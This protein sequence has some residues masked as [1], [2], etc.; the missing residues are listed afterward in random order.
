M[1]APGVAAIKLGVVTTIAAVG[2]SGGGGGGDTSVVVAQD[3][4]KG[5]TRV[6]PTGA[7]AAALG[8]APEGGGITHEVVQ[9]GTA[10]PPPPARLRARARTTAR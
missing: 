7:A 5:T 3:A 2:G 9:R 4:V 1:V 8:E 6:E 10:R